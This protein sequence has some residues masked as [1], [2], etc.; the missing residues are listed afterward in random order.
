M[1][2]ILKK[3]KPLLIHGGPGIG[4]TYQSL[5]L[6]KNM[7]ITKI[8]SS[9]L[10]NIKNKDF[11]TDIAKKRNITLMFNEI[12]ENRCLLIDDL[13]IYQKHDKYLFKLIIEFIKNNKYY[14]T[15]I[16]LICNDSLLKNKDI[17][18]IKNKLSY[19]HLKYSYS[20]YYKICL[21][22]LKREK[23]NLLLDDI[24]KK[25]FF[26]NFNFNN[27]IS[28]CK[29]N[30]NQYNSC[31]K[32]KFYPIENITKNLIHN[33]YN[34]KELIRL[35]EG[36]EIIISYNLLENLSKIINYNIKIY[37]DIYTKFIYSDIIE[38]NLIKNDKENNIKYL[39]ILAIMDINYHINMFTENII[40]NKYI[41][42]SMVLTKNNSLLNIHFYIY[43]YDSFMKYKDKDYE[44][45]LLCLDS[46]AHIKLKYI[47]NL[48]YLSV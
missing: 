30:Y 33:K 37:R 2:I 47:Y 23:I 34:I 46:K 20:E 38:Y 5:E 28:E 22:I 18:K 4:K 10:K 7:V 16:I 6:S 35:C 25:I 27:F 48:Y 44:K 9:M 32:D 29:I 41:S 14:D 8:D 12:K 13:H 36:D 31:E 3:N 42:K 17:L 19:Y 15:Y 11:L 1:N 45:K 21:Q 40:Q 24:D 43:L 39:S 26:S